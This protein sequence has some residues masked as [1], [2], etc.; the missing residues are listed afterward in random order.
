MLALALLQG[1]LRGGDAAL[2]QAGEPSD[3]MLDRGATVFQRTCAACHGM[4]AGGQP[5]AGD[6]AGPAIGDVDVARIDLVLRTGR[7]PIPSPR[8]GVRADHLD[9]ADREAV[10]AWMRDRFELPGELPEPGVGQASRGL[11]PFVRN[12]AGCHGT[13]GS[14]GVAGGGTFVPSIRG[15]DPV[16]IAEATRVGP[17]EMPPFSDTLIDDGELADIIS[18]LDEADTAPRTFLGLRE[19]D[20][21]GV[22]FAVVVLVAAAIGVLHLVSDR[23]GPDGDEPI[24]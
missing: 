23:P 6:D 4:Q 8:L 19:V 3:E 21:V 13:G 9:D 12:C 17:F 24:P 10:V 11:A 16:A 14:G 20:A 22:A 7:M 1:R 15:H 18:Y 2:A 5:A